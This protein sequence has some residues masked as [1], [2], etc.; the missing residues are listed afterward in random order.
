VHAAGTSA[1]QRRGEA[2]DRAQVNVPCVAAGGAIDP[3]EMVP[4]RERAAD[5]RRE[6]QGHSPGLALVPS[7][8]Q[9]RTRRADVIDRAS[10]DRDWRSVSTTRDCE[11][12][13]TEIQKF[14]LRTSEPRAVLDLEILSVRVRG[15]RWF[16]SQASLIE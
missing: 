1:G 14:C 3:Q 2:R 10:A 11:A 12:P 9:A 6:R 8:D 15:G 4:G 5:R 13:P 16:L 7:G